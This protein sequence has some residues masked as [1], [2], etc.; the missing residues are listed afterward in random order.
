MGDDIALNWRLCLREGVG[1]EMRGVMKVEIK[2]KD[3]D[4]VINKHPL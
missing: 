1:E 4:E 3:E 2:M